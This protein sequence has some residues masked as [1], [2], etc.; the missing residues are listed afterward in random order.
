MCVLYQGPGTGDLS[1]P[2]V[3]GVRLFE[4]SQVFLHVE[5]LFEQRLRIPFAAGRGKKITAIDMDGAR[6]PQ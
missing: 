3:T 4:Q 5:R 6:H 1:I 2:N